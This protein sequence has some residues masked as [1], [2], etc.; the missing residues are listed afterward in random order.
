[1]PT[2]KTIPELTGVPLK[3]SSTTPIQ[4]QSSHTVHYLRSSGTPSVSVIERPHSPETMRVESYPPMHHFGIDS[5]FVAQSPPRKNS[6]YF[7][8]PC[9]KSSFPPPSPIQT[10]QFDFFWDPFLSLD[11][12][13]Y[14]TRNSLDQMDIDNEMAELRQACEEKE[15]PKLEEENDIKEAEMKEE[16]VGEDSDMEHGKE[17]LQ[18]QSKD[19]TEVSEAQNGVETKVGN[20]EEVVTRDGEASLERTGFTVYASRRPTSMAEVVKDLDT[21]FSTVCNSATEVLRI[22]EATGPQKSSTATELT[23]AKLLNPVALF[24]STS[25]PFF[26]ASSGTRDDG[27]DSSNDISDES[28][29]LRRSHRSTLDRLCEWEKKLYEEVKSG[30]RIRRAY[31]KKCLQIMDVKDED[32][33]VDEKTKAMIRDL[34]ARMKVSMH[35][36]G[37]VSKRIKALRDEELQ[38]QLM[39]LIRGLSRM[40][41]VIAECHVIQK[42]TIE[43]GKLILSDTPPKRSETS[44]DPDPARLARSAASLESELRNWRACFESWVTSQRSYVRSLAGWA[45]RCVR[46]DTNTPKFLF[47]SRPSNAGPPIFEICIQW[48]GFLDA[49]PE[50]G[51]TEGM[52]F[53]AA[54]VASVY[55]REE[56]AKRAE[57]FGG[58]VSADTEGKVDAA[59][60]EEG[61]VTEE[62][63]VRI[64]CAGMSAA[65]SSLTEFAVK[66]AERYEE[67]MK[68]WEKD[69]PEKDGA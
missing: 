33:S 42:R 37:S 26:H 59:E 65:V 34:H 7:S 45:Q 52:D 13:A 40:W 25:S 15:I 10:S 69:T 47:P 24:R 56:E 44:G 36:I 17:G 63:A 68:Q 61:R 64:L 9:H 43:E 5:F 50:A 54:G 6:P 19:S 48:S 8:S 1:M 28:W 35:T 41:R 23:A 31:E 62:V 66:S 53:F 46:S 27:S 2:K 51:A 21:Q 18:S 22:L 67:V 38:P 30:A 14:P 11:T 3:S 39:E 4:S 58:G 32:S 29:M 16:S 12:Y 49:V 60:R 55:G 57:R 20:G